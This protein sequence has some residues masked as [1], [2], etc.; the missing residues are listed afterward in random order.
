MIGFLYRFR[1]EREAVM[2]QDAGTV[3]IVAF[4]E[5]GKGGTALPEGQPR[6]KPIKPSQFTSNTA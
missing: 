1:G 2:T 5:R 6:W 3:G 4:E